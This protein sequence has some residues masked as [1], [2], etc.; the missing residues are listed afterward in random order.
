M[1]VH[2]IGISMHRAGYV[3]EGLLD[4]KVISSSGVNWF[5][6][7]KQAVHDVAKAHRFSERKVMYYWKAYNIAE[8]IRPLIQEQEANVSGWYVGTLDVLHLLANWDSDNDPTGKINELVEKF[9][10]CFPQRKNT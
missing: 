8:E 4:G 1:E 6:S 2:E 5:K 10:N 3:N 7:K 9:D